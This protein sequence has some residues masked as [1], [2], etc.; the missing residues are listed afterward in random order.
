[1]RCFTSET[2]SRRKST[3]R[4]D[5]DP[6]FLWMAHAREL[7]LDLWVELTYGSAARDVAVLGL[8]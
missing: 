2:N 6:E 3:M 7:L 4:Q 1:M 8:A 5:T